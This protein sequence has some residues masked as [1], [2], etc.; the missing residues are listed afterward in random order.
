MVGPVATTVAHELGHNFGLSH[1]NEKCGCPDD[2]CIM[3]ASSG[4]VLELFYYQNKD[5]YFVV[6]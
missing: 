5:V 4:C 2:R 3:A 1:D 6:F